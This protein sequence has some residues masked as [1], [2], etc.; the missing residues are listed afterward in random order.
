MLAQQ[1]VQQHVLL[2]TACTCSMYCL[3]TPCTFA[4]AAAALSDCLPSPDFARNLQER[5]Q[6]SATEAM[7]H[8]QTAQKVVRWIALSNKRQ[9]WAAWALDQLPAHFAA[10]RSQ[11]ALLQRQRGALLQ[12]QTLAQ[13][14]PESASPSQLLGW[15]D[16]LMHLALRAAAS[17]KPAGS[18]LVSEPVALLL[19]DAAMVITAMGST[20]LM[21]RGSV[22]VTLKATAFA[23]TPCSLGDQ[24]PAASTCCGNRLE[25]A[26]ASA[27]PA[28][29]FTSSYPT[30]NPSPPQLQAV[31]VHHKNSKK[32][33]PG[34]ALPFK[35]PNH[36][37]LLEM[38]EAVG[39]PVLTW[40]EG[41]GGRVESMFV[42]NNGKPFTSDSL[43]T[44]WSQVYK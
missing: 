21:H 43:C 31:I 11:L 12:T 2:C 30:L 8:L 27:R 14:E 37:L 19:R 39:R 5:A 20:A 41:E 28:A 9:P 34:A 4:T 44:W 42:D 16:D 25:R 10:T 35:D 26:P 17:T 13:P 6:G 38:Y 29:G 22:L 1:A 7:K 3:Q 24:C 36:C 32:A 23:H 40:L 18:G 15:A 33:V